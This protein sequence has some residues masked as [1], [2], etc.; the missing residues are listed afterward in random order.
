MLLINEWPLI[1]ENTFEMIGPVDVKCDLIIRKRRT[2]SQTGLGKQKRKS[3][4]K[5]AFSVKKP[6]KIKGREILLVDDVYTTGATTEECVKVLMKN[7]AEGIH[8]L[9]LARAI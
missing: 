7:G 1:A 8:I 4:I 5:N 6:G 3:N 2:E 9:T